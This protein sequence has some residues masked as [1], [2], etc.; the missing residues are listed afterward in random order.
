MD[1]RDLE[2]FLLVA[3]VQNIQKASKLSGISPSTLSKA[4]QRLEV[5]HHVK[6]FERGGRNI[7]LS[8]EG[9]FYRERFRQILSLYEKTLQESNAAEVSFKIRWALPQSAIHFIA[10][11]IAKVCKAFPNAHFE[12]LTESTPNIITRLRNREVDLILTSHSLPADITAKKVFH[13]DFD[14]YVG[15]GHAL[16]SKAKSGVSLSMDEVLKHSFIAPKANQFSVSQDDGFKDGWLPEYPTRKVSM[17][18][19]NYGAFQV[20]IEQGLGLGYYP[21]LMVKSSSILPLKI[22]DDAVHQRRTYHL[23]CRDKSEFGWTGI[24][25]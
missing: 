24:L 23:A 19:D 16:Y 9:Q 2:V 14:I 4:I 17:V 5:E 11:L 20:L 12:L 25:F 13:L 7:T 8:K 21:D 15:P 22:R 3:E 10:P 6:L 18:V 1:T